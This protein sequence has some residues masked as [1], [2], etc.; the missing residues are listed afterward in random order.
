MRTY[1]IIPLSELRRQYRRERRRK[2]GVMLTVLV[3]AFCM[4]C[5]A[6]YTF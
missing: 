1:E 4:A 3:I 2:N 5:A 6:Y